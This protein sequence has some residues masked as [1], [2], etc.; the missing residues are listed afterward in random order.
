METWL[1]EMPRI[2]GM[3][4]G[5][6]NTWRGETDTRLSRRID[7]APFALRWMDGWMDGQR[8]E[9]REVVTGVWASE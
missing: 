2:F 1:S 3:P 5:I 6:R 8:R 7:D 4:V 9:D